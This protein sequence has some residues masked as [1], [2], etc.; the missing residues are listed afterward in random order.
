MRLAT[1]FHHICVRY[2]SST[3]CPVSAGSS[4]EIH[5]ILGAADFVCMA[6]G[7]VDSLQDKVTF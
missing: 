3:I 1:K 7:A 5:E 6:A 2:T 4:C